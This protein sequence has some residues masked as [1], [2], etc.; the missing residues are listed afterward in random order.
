MKHSTHMTALLRHVTNARDFC[1][2]LED[3]G[4]MLI[5]AADLLGGADWAERARV[6]VTVARTGGPVTARVHTL[7]ALSRLLHGG[8]ADSLDG[9]EAFLFSSLHPDD[10]RATNAMR[11]AEALDRGLR[12]MEA[13]R[14][15]GLT[16]RGVTA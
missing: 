8:H 9:S 10:P 15:A 1:R 13:L 5:A 12:A 16:T 7:E 11:C 6:I 2:W 14:L 4:D 3:N